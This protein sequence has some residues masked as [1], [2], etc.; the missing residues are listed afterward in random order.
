MI[1]DRVRLSDRS[2][3]Y[4]WICR[5]GNVA[6]ADGFDPCLED[7]TEVE[8]TVDGPWAGRLYVCRRCGRII[9][10]GGDVARY[11]GRRAEQDAPAT[12]WSPAGE[13]EA[14]QSVAIPG[15]TETALVC[16]DARRS[17]VAGYQVVTLTL[18]RTGAAGMVEVT[19]PASDDV[20]VTS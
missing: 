11:F 5:C 1:A 18:W 10:Q 9:D 4:S 16:E 17:V 2:D 3:A 20:E 12:S 15:L 7:G 6:E 14:G 13:V 19:L 8:P